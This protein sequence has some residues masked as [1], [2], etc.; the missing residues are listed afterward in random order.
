MQDKRKIV[1]LESIFESSEWQNSNARLPLALGKDTDGNVIVP[2]L[3]RM[4][5][6][7]ISGV[8]GSGKSVCM[9]SII[10]GL[11]KKY[12]PAELKFIMA[13]LKIVELY[14]FKDLPHLQCPIANSCEETLTALQWCVKE[15]NRRYQV[16]KNAQC[17]GIYQYNADGHPKLPYIVFVLDE[18]SDLMVQE[19]EIA[20][21]TEI[22]INNICAKGRAAGVHLIILTSRADG[23]VLPFSM[24]TVIPAHIAFK[25]YSADN[26]CIMLGQP[27]GEK[28]KGFGDMLIQL[29]SENNLLHG[30]GAYADYKM[31]KAFIEALIPCKTPEIDPFD[32]QIENIEDVQ[33]DL[34]QYLRSSDTY[35]FLEAVKFVMSTG[36][37][38]TR[39]LQEHLCISYNRAAEYM[40]LLRERGV[41]Q[42]ILPPPQ[43]IVLE[44]FSIDDSE[45]ISSK[46]QQYLRP[47]DTYGFQLAVELVISTGKATI[48]HLQRN[49]KIG[50]NRAAEYMDLLRKRGVIKN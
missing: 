39:Y 11:L 36:E 34:R 17:R 5:H 18:L 2:D 26:S 37:I 42:Q 9:Y 3:A 21:A 10:L 35:G 33:Q 19:P 50:Y 13:D 4:P 31:I 32:L 20:H 30:Q 7:L 49:L 24:R 25:L 14:D 16:M 27:G 43:E 8:T 46:L 15:I 48:S 38:G 29:P 22:A 41:I 44:D 28:L 12:S 40:D 47:G 1:T 23:K 45:D 6:L